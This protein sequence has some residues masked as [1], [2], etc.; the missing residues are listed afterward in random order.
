MGQCPM[1]FAWC[2]LSRCIFFKSRC[3][4]CYY[5][6]TVKRKIKTSISGFW[7]YWFLTR[8]RRHSF[9]FL[10]KP[11]DVE[12]LNFTV[13]VRNIYFVLQ[14]FFTLFRSGKKKIKKCSNNFFRNI[15]SRS[16]TYVLFQNWSNLSRVQYSK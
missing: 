10:F 4:I 7:I 3:I 8:K 13:S 16:V 1:G 2:F 11:Y 6:F 12:E 5:S 9:I 14:T 15:F